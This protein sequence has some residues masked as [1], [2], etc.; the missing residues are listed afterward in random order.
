MPLQRAQ[1]RL[2]G[3]MEAARFTV[4]RHSWNLVLSRRRPLLFSSERRR[5]ARLDS[6][7]RL[8]PLLEPGINLGLDPTDGIAAKPDPH[9]K[10]AAFS[11]L[12]M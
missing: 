5:R 10:A 6:A 12:S 9:R 3:H 11:S 8:G 7:L 4:L 1:K 2:V